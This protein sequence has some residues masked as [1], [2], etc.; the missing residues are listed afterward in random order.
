MLINDPCY[1]EDARAFAELILVQDGM[2]KQDRL[3][4]AFRRA[5]SRAITEDERVVLEQLLEAHLSEY[6]ANPSAAAELLA[7]GTHPVSPGQTASELA[8]WTSVA[9]VILNLHEA[10]TRD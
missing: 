7:V 6:E 4:F 2:T 3:D 5:V 9:R 8:A 10:I 1:V